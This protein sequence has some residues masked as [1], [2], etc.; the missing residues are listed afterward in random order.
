ME[1]AS[2]ELV[3]EYRLTQSDFVGAYIAHYRNSGPAKTFLYY[4]LPILG[5]ASILIAVVMTVVQIRMGK[6]WTDPLSFSCSGCF[7]LPVISF[8]LGG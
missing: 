4:L 7:G 6:E 5:C 1:T 8:G 2:A 3:L